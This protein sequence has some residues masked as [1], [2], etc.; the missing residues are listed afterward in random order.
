[1]MIDGQTAAGYYH[2]LTA[3]REPFL[4]RARDVSKLTLPSLV[5]PEGHSNQTLPTPYQGLGARGVNSLASKLLLA[6][7][8]PNQSFIRLRLSPDALA[9]LG[10]GQARSEVDAALAG[11][12]KALDAEME[13]R[14]LRP[15]LHEAKKHLLVSG[16]AVLYIPREGQAKVY[17]LKDFV[18]KR[19]PSGN[20]LAMVIR[21]QISPRALPQEVLEGAGQIDPN[22]EFVEIYTAIVLEDEK[23]RVCQ[24]VGGEMIPNSEGFYKPEHL[25]WIPLR[26]EPISGQSYGYGY[27]ASLLG[28]LASLEGL[29][30]ALVEAA[31]ISARTVFLVNPSATTK[32]SHL[33]RADNG[34]FVSGMSDD[35]AALRVDKGADMGVAFQAIEQLTRSLG[36]SFL[37]N[38]SVQRSG[39]RVTAEEIRFLAQELEDVLAGTYSLL[40]QEEQ[41]PIVRLMLHHMER[42]GDIQKLD[43]VATPTIVTGLEALGRG[44]DLIRLDTFVQGAGQVLGPQALMQY[45]N[46][47]DYLTRRATAVGIQSS[48]LIR[49]EEEVQQMNQQQ[50]QAALMQTATPEA[51]RQMGNQL[52]DGGE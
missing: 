20:V 47:G 49:S 38:Q 40:A 10:E 35:I 3:E 44:H 32:I 19:D 51:I 22:A 25:P 24:E 23:Y 1:M 27:V 30:K 13:S 42:R 5:P 46:A 29:W 8:P 9:Q 11:I 18:I 21:E 36:F 26:M 39:E 2:N 45:L 14:A 4:R 34:S 28:D 15:Y 37:L 7:F 17:H 50:Q 43:G 48:G 52:N 16:N 12:E 31:A 33:N 41:L 6:L